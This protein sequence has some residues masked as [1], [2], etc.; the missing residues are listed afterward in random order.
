ML[1]FWVDLKKKIN[2]FVTK[3]N[4][5]NYQH[6]SGDLMCT[7][8]YL[9]LFS[10]QPVEWANTTGLKPLWTSG[11]FAIRSKGLGVWLM[12]KGGIDG[13]N[14]WVCMQKAPCCVHI[15]I[16][17]WCAMISI[18][19]TFHCPE[20]RPTTKVHQLYHPYITF[21]SQNI[22]LGVLFLGLEK[23]FFLSCFV[24][25]KCFPKV[26]PNWIIKK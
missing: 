13:E 3:N 2:Y 5:S 20:F 22:S 17:P 8:F 21:S 10:F 4:T 12:E 18:C 14:K 24:L 1:V 26:F 9:S 15:L 6:R 11:K 16:T 25:N 7:P 19:C 23:S